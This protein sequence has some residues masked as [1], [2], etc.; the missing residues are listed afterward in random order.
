MV[1]MPIQ[2]PG[3]IKQVRVWHR[4]GEEAFT[5]VMM[6]ALLSNEGVLINDLEY[7]GQTISS[8]EQLEETVV[9]DMNIF[10]EDKMEVT[11]L[12]IPGDRELIGFRI[13][14]RERKWNWQTVGFN[15]ITVL[16]D[17]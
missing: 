12:P 1:K 10:S 4:F 6:I 14:R 13:T 16:S 5:N 15:P 8:L 2:D 3:L 9:Q 11:T 17:N 7:K